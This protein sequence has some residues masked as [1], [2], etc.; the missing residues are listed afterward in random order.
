MLESSHAIPCNL[1]IEAVGLHSAQD[2]VM[3]LPVVHVAGFGI[4][5]LVKVY[6]HCINLLIKLL[7]NKICSVLLGVPRR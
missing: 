6:Q 4:K 5:H 2:M 3:L 7:R 1:L